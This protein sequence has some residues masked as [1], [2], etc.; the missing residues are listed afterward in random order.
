MEI[1]RSALLL[2]FTIVSTVIFAMDNNDWDE[3][4][5]SHEW[6]FTTLSTE[7]AGTPN[8]TIKT[9]AIPIS[10]SDATNLILHDIAKTFSEFSLYKEIISDRNM[11]QKLQKSINNALNQQQITSENI[12]AIKLNFIEQIT[13][14][15]HE[16]AQEKL[17]S[18]TNRIIINNELNKIIDKVPQE[19]IQQCRTILPFYIETEVAAQKSTTKL[20][21]HILF[22]Q[23]FTQK[24][25][26]FIKNLQD[27]FNTPIP[28][29]VSKNKKRQLTKQRE[30]NHLFLT[31]LNRFSRPPQV[32]LKETYTAL[33]SENTPDKYKDEQQSSIKKKRK[34][35]DKSKSEDLS[36]TTSQYESG[37]DDSDSNYTEQ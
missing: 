17:N 31:W 5:E 27:E 12:R 32:Y 7:F 26:R 4:I 36:D 33:L 30:L 25:E 1:T 10:T 3:I 2:F 18:E 35:N 13:P 14:M 6:H 11:Q 28:T 29:N 9:E 20:I 8:D 37:E 21:D 34:V 23:E 16:Q 22:N 24:H 19:L 15:L